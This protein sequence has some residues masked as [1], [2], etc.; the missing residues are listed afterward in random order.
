MLVLLD[1][2]EAHRLPHLDLL[3]RSRVNVLVILDR[4]AAPGGIDR[5][6]RVEP[7]IVPATVLL[8]R[9]ARLEAAKMLLM[10]VR[11]HLLHA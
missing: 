10:V 6:G 7:Q 11:G 9:E 3:H 5:R 1:L 8:D 2:V 4:E